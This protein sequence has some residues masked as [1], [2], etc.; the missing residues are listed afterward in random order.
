MKGLIMDNIII[1]FEFI[2]A[3]KKRRRN[4]RKKMILEIEMAKGYNAVEWGNA[5]LLL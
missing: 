4:V 3:L 2:Y 1:A 5:F